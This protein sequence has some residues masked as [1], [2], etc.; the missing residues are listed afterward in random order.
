[1]PAR[2]LN[3]IL[4][5]VVLEL[6]QVFHGVLVVGVDGNPFTTLRGRID[7]IQTDRDL[8]FQMLAYG[9]VRQHERHI[10]SFLA[11]P[12]VVVPS[13]L[14]MRTERLHGVGATIHKQF[15]VTADD[16]CRRLQSHGHDWLPPFRR[17]TR[18]IPFFGL[19]PTRS[20]NLGAGR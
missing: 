20:S 7:S 19:S 4:P 6:E 5:E 3:A 15:L 9:T 14:G 13:G 12:E 8:A 17:T 1:M 10:S 18:G 11:W 2:G 16:L